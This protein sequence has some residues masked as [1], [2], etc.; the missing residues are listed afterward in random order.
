MITTKALSKFSRRCSFLHHRNL[1]PMKPI[2]DGATTNDMAPSNSFLKG[3][4]DTR[5]AVSWS[6]QTRRMSQRGFL[7]HSRSILGWNSME[8]DNVHDALRL[9]SRHF[10]TY[11]NDKL[12]RES[13]NKLFSSIPEYVKIVEVGPRDG[14]Q[15]EKDIVPTAV[16]VELIKMLASSGLPVVEAT[17]FVSPKWVPQLADAKDVMEA[18]RDFKG[19]QFPVLT[20]NLKG[21][22]AA[23]AAGAKEVAVFASASE[24][25]SKSNI[26]CSIEDSLVRYHEVALSACKLSI[27]VR[28]YISCVVGCP[29][30]GM[31]SPSK[32]AYVAKKLCDMGC[33]E[34]SLGDTIGVGTPGTVIPMLEAVIDVVPIEKLAVHFHDTYGQALSNILASLQMGI[35]TVDSSVSGLGGCPYAK[36]ASG[37][38]ATEDVV[39]MLNGLGVKTNVDLQK[40]MLA[41]N[42]IRKHLGHSSGSKTAIALSKITA[43]ASKL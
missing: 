16:K 10:S 23:I 9:S 31:V 15:N 30:E 35:S 24:G 1:V 17:S 36:G 34:I 13:T 25:F 27:P 4:N 29:V 8:I 6:G 2:L 19:A 28:G 14:L 40:I 5:E 20:P 21:F 32:V 18:I 38:V 43:H 11:Y 41:G 42:F 22:E 39:Y 33:Y 3:V 37:N 7:N 26:N 12:R